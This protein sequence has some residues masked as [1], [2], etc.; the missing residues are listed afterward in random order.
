MPLYPDFLNGI[1]S[2]SGVYALSLLPEKSFCFL[3]GNCGGKYYSRGGYDDNDDD[4]LYNGESRRRR[5]LR[6]PEF[7]KRFGLKAAKKSKREVDFEY[8]ETID[9]DLSTLPAE[10]RQAG[11]RPRNTL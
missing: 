5:R 3:K 10:H 7:Y 4:Y 6:E 2:F 11:V 8:V 1:S 9:D